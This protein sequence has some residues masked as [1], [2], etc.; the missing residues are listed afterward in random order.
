MGMAKLLVIMQLV[1]MVRV[2]G[3]RRGM[4]HALRL[5]RAHQ[6]AADA[7]LFALQTKTFA[8]DGSRASVTSNLLKTK[9]ANGILG[10]FSFDRNGD[11]TA[12]AVTI[13]R[14]VGGLQGDH[15]AAE[16]R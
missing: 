9:V 7:S 5:R 14:I 11:T 12:G 13:Y 2:E 4:A 15:A 10:S 8:P 16:P 1:R 6:R 3:A